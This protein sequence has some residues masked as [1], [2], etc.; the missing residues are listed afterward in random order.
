MEMK[1]LP[2]EEIGKHVRQFVN[3]LYYL[4]F[5]LLHKKIR[6]S[7]ANLERL[8]LPPKPFHLWKFQQSG[9]IQ[10]LYVFLKE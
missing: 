10:I 8:C 7:Q 6:S 2:S 1:D 3:Y 4:P 9:I 5:L